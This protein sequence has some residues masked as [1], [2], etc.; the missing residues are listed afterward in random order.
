MSAE[1]SQIPKAPRGKKVDRSPDRELTQDESQ[2]HQVLNCP[3]GEC[4]PRYEWGGRAALESVIKEEVADSTEFLKLVSFLPGGEK[5]VDLLLSGRPESKALTEHLISTLDEIQKWKAR[6]TE[7]KLDASSPEF[8]ELV[9]SHSIPNILLK[10]GFSLDEIKNLGID[11]GEINSES[12][13]TGC[14]E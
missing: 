10:S 1:L 9:E 6:A 5:V 4:R 7:G 13:K 2:T 11:T 8:K 14:R 12:Q 3:L